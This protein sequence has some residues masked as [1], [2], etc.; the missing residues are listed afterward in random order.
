MKSRF[1]WLAT[2][3]VIVLAYLNTLALAQTAKDQR[4]V[5]VISID[6]FAAALVD[7]NRRSNSSAC[8]FMY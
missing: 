2:A 6:G 5:V 3:A 4:H 1:G 8:T 7:E